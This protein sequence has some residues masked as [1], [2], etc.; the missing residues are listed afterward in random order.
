[1]PRWMKISGIIA[2]ALVLLVAILM[3]TGVGGEHGPGLHTSPIQHM[4]QP[5]P[6]LKP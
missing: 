4:V 2:I 3:L 5:T 6:T 1:M